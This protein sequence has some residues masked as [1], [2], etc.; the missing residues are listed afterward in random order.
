MSEQRE[1]LVE[2]LYKRAKIRRSIECRKSVQNGE[3]DRIADLLEEAAATLSRATN[4]DTKDGIPFEAATEY[5]YQKKIEE[6]E[7]K[8]KEA[9]RDA[10]V[11]RAFDKNHL[12]KREKLETRLGE[13][14]AVSFLR[15]ERITEV[16]KRNADLAAKL[17]HAEARLE[18]EMI[19]HIRTEEKLEKA[20]E[21][22]GKLEDGLSY[23][24][25]RN[26]DGYDSSTAVRLLAE[27]EAWRKP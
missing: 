12:R 22:I 23:Y 9:E 2:R 17:A 3:P 8:L 24:R 10:D 4:L 13:E 25:S 26:Q 27:L 18:G 1:S 14:Q 5:L 21:M 16:T 6:L 15:G 7:A 20:E 11:L 19:R